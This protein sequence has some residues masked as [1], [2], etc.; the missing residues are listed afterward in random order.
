MGESKDYSRLESRRLGLPRIKEAVACLVALAVWLGVTALFIGFRPEHIFLALL[1]GSLFFVAPASRR[2][3]VALIPFALFGISYDWMN[4][5]PNYEVNPVD[6]RGL[7]E[8]EKSLFGI[9]VAEPGLSSGE[10]LLTPN[11]YFAIHTHPLMDFMAG[12]FYLCWVPLPIFYGLWVYFSGR[13][14]DYLRFALVFLLV[15]LIG[16]AG[17][18][19][20]PAAPPW[21]VA[22]HGFEAVPGTPGSVA[23]L[24]RFDQMTGLTVFHGLY[25]RNANVFAAMPSLHSAYTFVAFIYSLIIHSSRIWKCILGFVTLGIWFTAVYTSHHYILD[26]CGGIICSLLSVFLF[27]CILMR[28]PIFRHWLG[29]YASYITQRH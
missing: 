17:Y 11:E 18:Y 10:T 25:E 2:L 26:V 3:V 12:V 29:G 8:T 22:M 16:F 4:L 9:S 19:I 27:E 1:I 13:S 6:V 15:N 23:G 5:L 7:Y 20:H 24:A 28:W 14:F 21:Y